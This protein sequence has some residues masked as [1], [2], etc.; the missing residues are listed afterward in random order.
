MATAAGTDWRPEWNNMFSALREELDYEIT[1]IQGEIPHDLPAGAFLRNGPGFFERAGQVI[2]SIDADGMIARIEI[3]DGRA[4]FRNRYIRTKGYQVE[5]DAGKVM[6]RGPYGTTPRHWLLRGAFNTVT[7]NTGNTSLVYLPKQDRLLAGW[8]GGLPHNIDPR[9]L[10]TRGVDTLGHLTDNRDIVT[11]H[12]RICLET[13]NL[14]S[15]GAYSGKS[16]KVKVREYDLKGS[17]PILL[18][19]HTIRLTG[20]AVIHDCL[21]TPNWFIIIH[22]PVRIHLPK[23]ALGY[24]IDDFL[25]PDAGAAS[26]AYLVP[27]RQDQLAPAP[28]PASGAAAGKKPGPTSRYATVRLAPGFSYHHV[29]AGE[30]DQGIWFDT[31]QYARKPPLNMQDTSPVSNAMSAVADS[32]PGELTRFRVAPPVQAGAV[33]GLVEP[34]RLPG[35]VSME[36]PVISPGLTGRSHRFVFGVRT[37][38]DRSYKGGVAPWTAIAKTDLATGKVTYWEPTPR[39]F[40]GEPAFVPRVNATEED[41]GY[42]L[43]LCFDGVA[44]KSTLRILDAR[45]LRECC[46]LVLEQPVPFSFHCCWIPAAEYDCA[47]AARL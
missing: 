4:T 27:R 39:S 19:E 34:I 37:T 43:T 8:E 41:D 32:G 5:Q 40:V 12:P 36:M 45:D 29:N 17:D 25:L 22:N 38:A 3:R 23:L 14:W 15:F 44:K 33:P 6:F 7:K 18:Q 35:P 2:H 47:P 24:G 20:A 26:T 1:E 11:A 9:T 10:E 31:I 46:G 13:G 42:L 28:T 16:S 30:D 21:L